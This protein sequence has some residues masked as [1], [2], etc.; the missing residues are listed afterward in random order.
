MARVD[1]VVTAVR[2]AG[3]R[4]KGAVLVSD[5]F[6]PMPDSIEQAHEAGIAAIVQPGGSIKDEEVIKAC[7]RFGLPMVLTGVRHFR[8]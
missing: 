3:E 6:F 7:D 5:A 2:K 1:S 4:A 8:H